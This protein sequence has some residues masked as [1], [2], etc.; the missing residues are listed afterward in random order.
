MSA[1]DQIIAITLDLEPIK[2]FRDTVNASM[3]SVIKSSDLVQSSL[4][5]IST[6]ISAFRDLQTATRAITDVQDGLKGLDRAKDEVTSLYKLGDQIR[7]LGGQGEGL[8]NFGKIINNAFDLGPHGVAFILVV[9][10]IAAAAYLIIKNWGPITQFFQT[11]WTGIVVGLTNLK[12]SIVNFFTVTIPQAWTVFVAFLKTWGPLILAVTAPILGIPLLIIQNWGKISQFF[13]TLW[14]GIVVGLTNLKNSI[15]NFFTVTIPQ[16]WT[17]FVA[18]LKTWG[19]LILAIIAPILGIPLLIIQNWGQIKVFFMTLWN[20]IIGF[21]KTTIPNWVNSFIQWINK[22]PF[23]AGYAV[24]QMLASIV[25]FGVNLTKWAVTQLPKIIQNIVIW[26]QQLPGKIWTFLADIVA[27]VG[28][29]GSNLVQKAAVEIP[30][31]VSRVVA[32]IQELPGKIWAFFTDV[33]GKVVT[34]AG[35]LVSTAATEIPKFVKSVTDF[36]GEL[37]GK[38]L[39]IG[40]NIVTGI[41]NGING[42]IGWLHDKISEFCSGLVKG[43]RDKL[44]IQSPSRLF[45]DEIGRNIALGIGLGFSEH[46]PT[47]LSVM[48][49]MLP[50]RLDTFLGIRLGSTS[51]L[52]NAGPAYAGGTTGSAKAET[53]FQF[54]QNNYSPKAIGSAEAA[55]QTR[56]LLRQASLTLRR[57]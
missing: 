24:G 13:Q 47:V 46:I 52:Y 25:N 35:K 3:Q 44:K 29:W 55:R 36:F 23:Q 8:K 20:G 31:F 48:K 37:P 28:Q 27:K 1:A 6:G 10:A 5:G 56:N 12:N 57:H 42:A 51:A 49:D 32:V 21:F 33:V 54:T 9:S 38:M 15:V 39:D 43:F 53:T 16:A 40:K 34:W 45:A 26:F 14:T 22:L 30:L 7:L 11:L 4:A 18:F 50:T 19:P 41:W 17:V 2:A